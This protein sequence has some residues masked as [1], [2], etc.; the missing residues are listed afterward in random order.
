MAAN[1]KAVPGGG[2]A[3]GDGRGVLDRAAGGSGGANHNE[4][5]WWDDADGADG[6][7]GA[8]DGDDPDGDWDGAQGKK[9]ATRM[10]ERDKEFDS[11]F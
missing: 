9:K 1:V 10:S 2:G 3:G 11:F 7:D 5:L 8:D 4:D 6:A